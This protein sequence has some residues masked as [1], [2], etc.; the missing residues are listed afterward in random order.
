[1]MKDLEKMRDNSKVFGVFHNVTYQVTWNA[2][3]FAI[4]CNKCLFIDELWE[5]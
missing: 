2:Y 4:N 1:M 5:N 3:L